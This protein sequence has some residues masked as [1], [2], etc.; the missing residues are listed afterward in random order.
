[1]EYDGIPCEGEETYKV[2]WPIAQRLSL[3]CYWQCYWHYVEWVKKKV[4][5]KNIVNVIRKSEER[6]LHP[7]FVS[8][9]YV[10]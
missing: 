3:H 9:L 8:S 5:K 2:Y 6:V 1:M 7:L 4:K 10:D